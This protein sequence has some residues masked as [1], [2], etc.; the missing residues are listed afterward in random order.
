MKN[1]CHRYAQ[2][3][4]QIVGKW[5]LGSHKKEYTP[6]F[7]GFDTHFGCWNGFQDYYSHVATESVA[8]IG[9]ERFARGFDMRR[10]MSVAWDTAGKY[11]TDLF[12]EE[13][14]RIID[15]HN[16]NDPMFLYLSHLAPHSGNGLLQAPEEEIAKF[17]YIKNPERKIYATMVSKLDQSVG[18][19]VE[20]LK[21]RRMLE[22]SI[23]LFM[24]DNGAPTDGIWQ[25]YGSNYPLRGIKASPWEGGVRGVAAIWSPLIQERERVS[26]TLMFVS[27]WL[28]TLLFAAGVSEENI[29]VDG[30]N[31]WPELSMKLNTFTRRYVPLIIDDIEGY[32]VIF[33]HN[34]KFVNGTSKSS[35]FT[36]L[37][38]SGRSLDESRPRYV[39]ERVLESKAGAAITS[40]RTNRRLSKIRKKRVDRIDKLTPAKIL[41]LR[42][43]AEI[44][45]NVTEKERVPCNFSASP[46]IFDVNRDPCEMRNEALHLGMV[47][48]IKVLMQKHLKHYRS[49]VV[50]PN[51]KPRDARANPTH[52]N[53]TWSCWNDPPFLVLCK[54]RGS[55]RS[56]VLSFVLA[57]L[58]LI[59]T[60]IT[61]FI[62]FRSLKLCLHE[63][64]RVEESYVLYELNS[65]MVHFN[66]IS[67]INT[68]EKAL[69]TLM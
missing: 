8:E 20:A 31:M 4:S 26:N 67:T 55:N 37:G 66:E 42:K 48:I 47:N 33:Y 52:W 28:P 39:P 14:V 24:S 50:P 56:A 22:N 38:D 62:L 15:A 3:P 35:R 10:N 40:V 6:T 45:C 58:V 65:K 43:E 5:H 59:V 21:N 2:S 29:S 13:A 36:W 64:S 19:V 61:I 57:S 11:S 1:Y 53:N 54:T 9:E 17:S 30:F 44:H 41:Q 16:P 27:D 60:G 25:N 69:K 34:W 12:T 18:E 51:N 49:S 32:E 63:N 23:V 7:R 46:C 68:I